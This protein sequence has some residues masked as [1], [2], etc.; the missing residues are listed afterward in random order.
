MPKVLPY[1]E[2]LPLK[3]LLAHELDEPMLPAELKSIIAW[4]GMTQSEFGEKLRRVDPAFQRTRVAINHYLNRGG[5]NVPV[6]DEI[7]RASRRL[8]RGFALMVRRAEEEA[9][10]QRAATRRNGELTD[11][12]V[13]QGE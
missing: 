1:D 8:L 7:A 10:A 9:A 2:R 4:L 13:T 5:G 11:L 6:P 12:M 3:G